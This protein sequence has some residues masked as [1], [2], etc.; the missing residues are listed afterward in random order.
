MF[1]HLALVV[2]FSGALLVA[3]AKYVPYGS[4]VKYVPPVDPMKVYRGPVQIS[5]PPPLDVDVRK[6]IKDIKNKGCSCYQCQL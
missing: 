6:Q 2:V 4:R 3:N 5:L 1:I